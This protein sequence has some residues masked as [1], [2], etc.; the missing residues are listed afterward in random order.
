MSV[1]TRPRAQHDILELAE[2][3]GEIY[4]AVG[5]SFLTRVEETLQFLDQ[6]PAVGVEAPVPDLVDSA[7]RFFPVR[8]FR[9]YLVAF[10]PVADGIEVLRVI[11]GR[12]DLEEME[13]DT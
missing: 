4:P 9:S 1:H 5:L 8:R 3:L 13:F 6:F 10:M 12:R 7:I 2:R 11:D